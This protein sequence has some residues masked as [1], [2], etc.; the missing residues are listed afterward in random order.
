MAQSPNLDLGLGTREEDWPDPD[1]DS[2]TTEGAEAKRRTEAAML[3]TIER[4]I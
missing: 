3:S 4:S 1:V 2:D